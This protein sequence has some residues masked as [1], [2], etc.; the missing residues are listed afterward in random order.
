MLY[1]LCEEKCDWISPS[2][3]KIL[4]PEDK[5]GVKSEDKCQYCLYLTLLSICLIQT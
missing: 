1:L 3:T 2:I 5:N 4:A